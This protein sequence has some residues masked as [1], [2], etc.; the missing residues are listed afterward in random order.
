MCGIF[1]LL[2]AFYGTINNAQLVEVFKNGSKRGPDN[3]V[4][5]EDLVNGTYIGFHRLSING[6]DEKSNQPIQ[7][8]NIV[9]MCNGEIYNDK[10]LI[11][12]LDIETKTNSDCEVIIHLY[13]KYGIDKTVQM[14]DGVFSFCLFDQLN[15][16][17]YVARDPFG[18]RPLY[19][20][21]VKIDTNELFGFSST[22]SGLTDISFNGS[23]IT[24]CV[25]QFKPGHYE[26]Y[27]LDEMT[28]VWMFV[29][30]VQYY[31]VNTFVA[32]NNMVGSLQTYTSIIRNS[33]EDAVRKRVH[34]TERDIAC[35]LS[36]G[37]DSSLITSLVSKYY[38]AKT[39]KKVK[40][41]SIGMRGSTDLYY[42]KKVSEFLNTEHTELCLDEQ[43]FLDKI[44]EVIQ[45]IETFDTTTVRA[46]VG[47]YLVSKCIRNLTDCKVIFNGDGSDEVCGGYLY[48]HYAE[49]EYEFDLEC[50]RLLNNIHFFDVLR[51]DRTISSNGLEARTPFL[52]KNFVAS[53]LS[54]PAKIRYDTTKAYGEKYLLRKAFDDGN[55]LPKEVLWRTKEAFSD[56]VSKKTRSWYEVIQEH[57]QKNT[58][59]NEKTQQHNFTHMKPTTLEQSYYRRE[60]NKHY[61][62][63]DEII[64]YFWMPKF[65][66]ASDAS[67][68]TLDIYK[69]KQT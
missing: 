20:A 11:N 21:S 62:G 1:A 28:N 43:D 53:F 58:Y 24:R 49:N 18:V 39:G 29:K 33:L 6:L 26:E 19:K 12:A 68:R 42:A 30:R 36:G 60:F 35:L 15:R 14:L 4:L 3:S 64:P 55:T 50:K 10:R 16:K 32:T 48:F 65:I 52:D 57:V 27:T 67:A 56:G 7:D 25:E 2:N 54:I 66:N 61:E 22:L 17:L 31:N 37:L 40:T 51:S 44:P 69:N 41:F 46:S 23:N 45:H 34:N 9:L 38:K 13:L 59:T 63:C 5:F 8:N 47:N